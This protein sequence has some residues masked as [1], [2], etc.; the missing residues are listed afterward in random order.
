MKKIISILACVCLLLSVIV[1]PV[2]AA[3][4]ATITFD[5][6]AKRTSVSTSQ[7]VWE[8]NGIKVTNNK[9][10]STSNVNEQ[11]YNPLRCYKSSEVIVEYPGM[12]KLVISAVSNYAAWD[13]SFT[14]SNATATVNG[15]TITITFATPVDSFTFEKMSAQCRANSMTVYTGDAGSDPVEPP[16]EEPSGNP[17]PD[18]SNT[19]TVVEATE[20]GAAQAASA[21]TTDKYYVTGVV[22]AIANTTYG[23]L[24]I[25]DD[26]G[27]E[28]YVYGLYNS[29]GT[30]RYDALDVQPNEGDTI[31]VYSVVGN[32]KGTPQLKNAWLIEM[33]E[34]ESEPVEPDPEADST[35]TVS[36]AIALG[37][38]KKN[39]VY[40]ENKYYVTGVITE[41]YNET[42]GNMYI[43]DDSGTTLTVYGTY[44]E[45][46]S[47]RY[48]AME[49][50]P[51]AGDTVTV[52]GVIGKYDDK[53]QMKN[54]WI[55]LFGAGEEEIVVPGMDPED[56][57]QLAVSTGAP[58]IPVEVVVPAGYTVFLNA[59]DPNGTLYVTTADGSYMLINGRQNQLT[60]DGEAE[61][62]LC[63]YEV[64][65]VYNPSETDTVTLYVFLTAGEV[66]DNS[67]TLDNP[68]EVVIAQNM[69]G[70]YGAMAEYALAA[71]SEG[72]WYK[73]VAPEDGKLTVGIGAFDDDYNN[74]GWMY[75]VNNQTTSKY[76]DNHYS[77]DAEPV[78]YEELVV[79]AGDEIYVFANTYDPDN[80]WSAPAG[81]IMVDFSFS[82]VGSVDMPVALENL[83]DQS[84][85]VAEGTNGI[86]Y[87]WVADK[88]GEVEVA[89]KGQDWQYVVNNLST[90]VYGDTHWSDDDPVVA[91][92]IVTVNEGDV[93]RISINTYDPSNMW[94]APAGTVNWTIAY[95]ENDDVDTNGT[96]TVADAD[97]VAGKEFTVAIDISNNPG[98]ISAKLNVNYDV[99]VLELVGVQAGDF[100]N[101]E[102][103]AGDVTLYNYTFSENLTDY[104]FVINWSSPLAEEN[105]TTD[106]TFVY[107]T[108]KVKATAAEGTTEISITVDEDNT[109]DFELNNV[110][111]DVVNATVTITVEESTIMYGDINGDG[112]VNGRDYGILLQYLN[113]WDVTIDLDA[114]DVNADGRVNGRDYG[115]LLQYLNDWPVTLGPS[116]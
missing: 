91:S 63:G 18:D 61:L 72:R 36:E 20:L 47:T 108:F 104:P 66:V 9:G 37:E 76:G 50:K 110:E 100:E 86:W 96:F 45:D 57:I 32:Y 98:I 31:T 71:G 93:V 90:Y 14:D 59:A 68:E 112:R 69:W 1:I 12:T 13:S 35:L 83:G 60:A 79:S 116:A 53:A 46:G 27:N 16:V 64:I 92:E 103:D 17:T 42:Y 4:S 40:T 107:L 49:T 85:T 25:A 80:M 38:S 94:T 109:V 34:G 15:L 111:F 52:Y 105:V 78:Y 81:N 26:E 84:T 21:Y 75:V 3:D 77:D 11:Y 28:L 41:V 33:T 24:Y 62:V 114:A 67:G 22:T 102:I 2:S 8:E 7:Q 88:D 58:V 30:V 43:T 5:N 29:D 73:A 106:G 87:E 23:N 10:A 44:S 55:T 74:I 82:P 89:M 56:P 48:D 113:D 101:G 51:V 6:L 70:G 19:L 99:N 115:I 54:A 65:N 97:A 39:N 95:V